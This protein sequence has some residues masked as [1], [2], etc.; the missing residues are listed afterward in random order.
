MK[1]VLFVDMDYFFA[2]C[3]EAR[4][5][6]LKDKAFVVGTATIAKKERGVVQTCNYEARKFGIHSAMATMQAIK[7]KPDLIYLES[8]DKYY[9]EMSDK[10]MG[11]LK[12]YKFPMEVI[13]IDEAALD[14][15]EKNYPKAESLAR[16]IKD[17][18]RREL[19][20]PCTIG[21]SV[22][23]IYAKMVCDSS[24][25]NG[26]GVLKEEDI[27]S[28]LKDRDITALLGV[29]R[30]TADRL[31]AMGIKTIGELSKAD[32]NV[33]VEKFGSF[34]RELFSLANGRD[35]SRIQES[36]SVMSVGRER[37]LERETKDMGEI[38]DM[39]KVLSKEVIEEI[40]KQGLWFKGVSVKARYYDLTERIKNRKLNNY[41]D[42]FDILYSTSTQLIRELVGEKNIRKVGVRTYLLDKRMGQK[43]ISF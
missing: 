30:K 11:M 7:L 19:K 29:G 22:G 35:E 5:P 16:E 15:G 18:I 39:L 14:L 33:L 1:L 38:D 24:K 8:D 4:H 23:K 43:R 9:E 2:A 40:T 17:R 27:K 28:F 26:I 21:V 31:N 20:L 32:P 12:G 37:T 6:E 10:V 42:S 13:S 25:P 36:Y 41:T 3:E 34:G